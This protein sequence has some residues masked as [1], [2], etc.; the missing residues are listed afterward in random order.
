MLSPSEIHSSGLC[1]S[2]N[3][4]GTCFYRAKRGFDAIYC[5]TFDNLITSTPGDDSRDYTTA[6]SGEAVSDAD[7]V[8]VQLKGLCVNCADRDCCT[9][10]KLEGGVWHCEEYR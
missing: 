2:C 1:S 3:N 10:P 9:L 4:V 5:E 7:G 6:V 8:P